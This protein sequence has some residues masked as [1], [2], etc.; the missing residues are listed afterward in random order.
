MTDNSLPQGGGNPVYLC[1]NLQV[2]E[3]VTP[4][5]YTLVDDDIL[6]LHADTKDFAAR[7]LC[8]LTTRPK[9]WTLSEGAIAAKFG[10]DIQKVKKA[11]KWLT[12]QGYVKSRRR[13]ARF[14]IDEQG[15]SVRNVVFWDWTVYE[16]PR[17]NPDY[18]KAQARA[19]KVQDAP[20][21]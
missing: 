6:Y 8:Y 14:A 12:D 7:V 4:V 21:E 3:R 11:M 20:A 1:G 19:R 5:T 13:R 15:R 18:V 17:M 2:V 9:P 10:T 16:V